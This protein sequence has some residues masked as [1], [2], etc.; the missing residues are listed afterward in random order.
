MLFHVSGSATF[1]AD[2]IHALPDGSAV[3]PP[4]LWELQ[5]RATHVLFETDLD[6]PPSVP[7]AALLSEQ[8]PLSSLVPAATFD[9]ASSLWK[10][11]GIKLPLETLKPWFAGLVL[12]SSLGASLGFEP[13]FGVDKQV[14][15][16]TLPERRFVLEGVEALVAFDNAPPH[17]QVAYL[18]M[19]ARTPDV[20]TGRLQRLV[21]YW[22]SNNATGFEEEL[23]VAKQQFPSMFS[24]LIDGRNTAWLPAIIDLVKRQ[25]PSL[26][27]VGA[28][29]LV[30]EAG[31]PALLTQNGYRVSAV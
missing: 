11:F 2:S 28:L 9:A 7:P 1:L 4:A 8:T 22:H 24:S 26:V 5:K 20:I 21:H 16:A 19:I 30:G 29:H 27:L 15:R 31:L 14:W 23:M 18:T 3:V 6:C 25:T 12:A 13:R 10:Q 17:E